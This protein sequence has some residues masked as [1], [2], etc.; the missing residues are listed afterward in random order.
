M[1]AVL[2]HFQIKYNFTNYQ[3]A[4]LKFLFITLAS[5]ISKILIMGIFFYNKLPLY[6]FA[7]FV[8][9][10]LRST[11][12]GI[13]FYT[14]VSCLLASVTFLWLAIRILPLIHLPIFMSLI[15]LLGCIITCYMI[16]PV[17]SKYRPTPS[18]N[19]AQKYRSLTCGFVFIYTVVFYIFP[20]NSYLIIG[21]WVIILHSLQLI[22]AKL[23]RK[24]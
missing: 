13:H 18:Q 21:F 9:L 1:D 16:G 5:E 8:M 7:I 14:Y 19:K 17:T 12:G 24:E 15:L 23:K 4:Q 2:K 22:L 6:F 20:E 10:C 3:I 11:T